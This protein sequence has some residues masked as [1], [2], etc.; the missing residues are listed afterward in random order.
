MATA[1]AGVAMPKFAFAQ[2]V[3]GAHTEPKLL[4]SSVIGTNHGHALVMSPEEALRLL[5][6]TK[7]APPALIDIKGASS[8]PHIVELTHE[9]LQL[10]FVD[11][12][13]KKESTRVGNHTHSV[14]VRLEIVKADA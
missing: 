4:V 10:L 2:E 14:E 7:N 11:G 3:P 12:V 1:A 13:V 8:H 6:F 9:D 5:R